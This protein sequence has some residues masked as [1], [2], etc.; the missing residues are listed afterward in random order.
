MGTGD[1]ALGLHQSGE[2]RRCYPERQRH[3]VAEHSPAGVDLRD[4]SK[5]RRV[6]LDVSKRLPGAGKR[7]LLFGGAVGVVERG[8][9]GTRLRVIMV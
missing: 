4:A 5:D 9:P 2:A 7:Q 8:F 6:K 1:L 3:A